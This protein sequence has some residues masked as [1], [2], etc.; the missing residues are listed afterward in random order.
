MRNRTTSSSL[1]VI[2]WL[3]VAAPI[4]AGSL[5][6]SPLEPSNSV[7]L[8]VQ[9][10]PLRG[11]PVGELPA[12]LTNLGTV[13]VVVDNCHSMEV[14]RDRRWVAESELGSGCTGTSTLSV[15]PGDSMMLS[16]AMLTSRV[17][18]ACPTGRCTA[19]A[20]VS[21]R[22]ESRTDYRIARSPSFTLSVSDEP[23]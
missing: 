22:E 15:A 10:G 4:V 16:L 21:Y 1:K 23:K 5:G 13:S 3:S 7:A 14:L 11:S 6:C 20:L 9:P 8:R 12:V 2:A 18:A 19:R 17:S